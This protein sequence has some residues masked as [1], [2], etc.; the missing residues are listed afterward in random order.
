ME[1][2]HDAFLH[3][4][5]LA[6]TFSSGIMSLFN[7]TTVVFSILATLTG[8]RKQVCVVRLTQANPVRRMFAALYLSM[9]AF[10]VLAGSVPLRGT[11]PLE[12][13]YPYY[14]F[15]L[16]LSMLLAIA[17]SYMQSAGMMMCTQLSTDGT[18]MGYMLMGQALQGV[19]GSLVNL[20]S[21][22]LAS[23]LA[24]DQPDAVAAQARE[25]ASAAAVVVLTTTLLQGATHVC[26]V[27]AAR[28][29]SVAMHVREWEAGEMRA[30]SDTLDTPEPEE[31]G[32]KERLVRVQKQIAP[33]SASIFTVF[34][35]TL[36][37]YPSLTALVRPVH[38]QPHSLWSDTGVF[39]AVHIVALNVGDLLGRR[40]PA[41]SHRFLIRQ[42]WVAIVCTTARFLFLPLFFLCNLV[43]E[44]K[45]PHTWVL[46]DAGFLLLVFLLGVTTGTNATSIFV[47]GPAALGPSPGM[48][49]ASLTVPDET[50]DLERDRLLDGA[51]P[52]AH[53]RDAGI[54]SMLLSFWLVLGLT[55]GS[56][57]SFVVLAL[58]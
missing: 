10:L 36:G 30:A 35:V 28:I 19:F 48:E 20:A 23:Q 40:L 53:D 44:G 26:F 58:T 6:T 51:T 4:P 52:W 54:A 34:L 57:F 11:A 42:A 27:R 33:W 9:A 3:T 41:L 38:P 25:N 7:V 39:V 46:P 49:G 29:P 24:K 16:V 2:F 17:Q 22:L 55:A 50:A 21:T 31:Q 47:S 45:R 18:L 43:K 37:L 5:S 12:N 15:L 13:A 32:A 8:S 1:Y 14:V 56:C